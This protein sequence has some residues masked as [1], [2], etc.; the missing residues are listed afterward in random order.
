MKTIKIKAEQLT[1]SSPCPA[2]AYCRKL[3]KEGVD[4]DTRLEVYRGDKE[5]FDVAISN[6]GEGAKWTIREEP[7][8]HI[9]KYRGPPTLK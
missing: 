8:L 9:E 4:P 1:K 7:N 2:F 5:E 6:I 3:I